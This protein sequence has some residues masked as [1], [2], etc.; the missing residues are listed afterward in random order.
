MKTIKY[1]NPEE[2]VTFDS[3]HVVLYT[4]RYE[5]MTAQV[6]SHISGNLSGGCVMETDFY[7]GL[8]VPVDH[9]L[10][11]KHAILEEPEEDDKRTHRPVEELIFIGDHNGERVDISI[12]ECTQFLVGV[13]I[14]AYYPEGEE[15]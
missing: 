5:N 9:E 6:V 4:F 1:Y 11:K 2:T 14:V 15:E 7:C 10:T 8:S 13:Q 12:D 3:E